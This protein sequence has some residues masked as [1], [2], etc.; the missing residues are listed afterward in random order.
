GLSGC[1]DRLGKRREASSLESVIGARLAGKLDSLDNWVRFPAAQS[2]KL[3]AQLAPD[4]RMDWPFLVKGP[5]VIFAPTS[6]MSVG[7]LM[8]PYRTV[9]Q[10]QG[11]EGTSW[12]MRAEAVVGPA[13]AVNHLG[14]R[15]GLTFA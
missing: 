14:K 5:A 8:K 9:R 1:L 7:E 6:A 15:V 13:I 3:S 2:S 10:Q 11:K 4:G 12:P